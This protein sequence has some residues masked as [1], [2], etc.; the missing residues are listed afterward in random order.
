MS[1]KGL[2]ELS[3][4]ELLK[5]E[6]T[7]KTITSMLAGAIFLLFVVNIFLAFKKGF[8]ALS[9]V[10]IAL[11]PIVIINF[12]SLKEMKKEIKARGL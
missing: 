5:N 4:E 7:L 11:L 8:S 3:N 6:K 2:S 10:P 12:N 9:A 1:K